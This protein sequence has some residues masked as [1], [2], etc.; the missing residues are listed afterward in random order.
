MGQGKTIRRGLA[1]RAAGLALEVS[2]QVFAILAVAAGAV[3]LASGATPA[4]TDVWP[5]SGPSCRR[6]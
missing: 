6:S 4:F 1:A 2:P 5:P 3:I